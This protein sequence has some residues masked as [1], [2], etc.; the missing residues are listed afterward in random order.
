M[1]WNV[2]SSYILRPKAYNFVKNEIDLA[3]KAQDMETEHLKFSHSD[4]SNYRHAGLYK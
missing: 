4:V 1:F 3:Y 2:S